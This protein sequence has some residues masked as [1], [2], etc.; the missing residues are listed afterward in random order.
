MDSLDG[1]S[2]GAPIPRRSSNAGDDLFLSELLF[3]IGLAVVIVLLVKLFGKPSQWAA[4]G[5]A[6]GKVAAAFSPWFPV[7]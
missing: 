5:A 1:S 2:D 3:W 7:R 4:P 6:V